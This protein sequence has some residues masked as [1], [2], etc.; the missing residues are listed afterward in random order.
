MTGTQPQ[1]SPQCLVCVSPLVRDADDALRSGSSLAEVQRR[2][3]L[4]YQSLKRH[5]RN[6]H[7]AGAPAS[8]TH[9]RAKSKDDSPTGVLRE[10]L[11]ALRQ[12]DPTH[13]SQ[14]A[15]IARIDAI[16]RAGEALTK[17]EPAP[18]QNA[19]SV[20]DFLSAE[21]GVMRKLIEVLFR[22][23]EKYPEVRTGVLEDLRDAG[24]VEPLPSREDLAKRREKTK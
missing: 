6:G 7:V 23:L 20:E 19:M 18:R 8:V 10:A 15:Q 24:I 3:S 11:D 21:G 9:A 22:R 4:P 16:R 5:R 1:W 12:M 17:I 13:M 14:N 2:T